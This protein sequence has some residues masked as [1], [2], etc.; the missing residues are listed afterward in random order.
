MAVRRSPRGTAIDERRFHHWLARELPAGHGGLLPLGDDAAAVRPPPGTVAV[1]SIDSL[2]EGTHFRPESPPDRVGAAAAAVSLSDLAAKGA[3]PTALLLAIVVP[4]GTPEEW[5]RSVA[6]GAERMAQRYGMAL[7]GGDTKPGPVRTVVSSV[8][9]W[10][11]EGALAPRSGARP[12]DLLATTGTVGRG[13]AAAARLFRTKRPD[14]GALVEMLAVR[15]R[16]AEG[17]ALARWAH[18]MLDTSDG[19]AEAARLLAEASGVRVEVE[20][21]RLP[22]SRALRESTL[23]V[24]E[25]RRRAFYGGDYELLLSLP[26]RSFPAAHKAVRRAGGRLTAI[27]RVTAGRDAW[28]VSGRRARPMPPAGW[29]PFAR[30]GLRRR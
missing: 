15:P 21:D 17:A 27:G 3:D 6:R 10:A 7:V 28:L 29:R 11:R 30:R 13:G 19:L 18:A 20:W 25:R 22:L 14:R 24:S 16:V 4:V 1:L 26:A 8:V 2:V 5:A 12:G 23:S 9:G